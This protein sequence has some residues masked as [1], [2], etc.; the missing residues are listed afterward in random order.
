MDLV[1]AQKARQ[2]LDFLVGF[3][4]SPLLW[5]KITSGLS[6]GRVRSPALG[7]IVEREIER[8]NFVKKD[9][10]SLTAETFKKK[11]FLQV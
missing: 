6:A 10:W 2:A 5:C 8:E 9:Y 7:M 1:N 4:L 11:K 3:N